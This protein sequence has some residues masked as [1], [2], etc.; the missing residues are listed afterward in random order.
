MKKLTEW[1]GLFLIS[2]FVQ[3]GHTLY[4]WSG[5]GYA[6]RESWLYRSIVSSNATLR[7]CIQTPKI[8]RPLHGRIGSAVDHRL[9]PL[10]FKFRRGH[11]RGP[12][13]IWKSPGP[14][15]YHVYKSGGKASTFEGHHTLTIYWKPVYYLLKFAHYHQYIISSFKAIMFK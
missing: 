11:V 6:F 5:S 15:A 9:L 13:H 10:E 8:I 14:L 2:L 4:V 1:S 3:S 7:H 12:H